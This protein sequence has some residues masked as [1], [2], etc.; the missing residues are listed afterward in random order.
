MPK[1]K[2]SVKRKSIDRTRKKL[3]LSYSKYY[4]GTIINTLRACNSKYVMYNCIT[5]FLL[6]AIYLFHWY[7]YTMEYYTAERRNS[8]SSQH[9]SMDGP[10]EYYA[11]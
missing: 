10:G 3:E 9:N 8:Y 5:C 4:K 1:S 7:I 6:Y 11:K 2:Q